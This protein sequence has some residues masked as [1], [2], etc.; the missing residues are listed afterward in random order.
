[1]QATQ[2]LLD[3]I[4]VV[5][6]YAEIYDP[7]AALSN[8]K[9]DISIYP[10]RASDNNLAPEPVHLLQSL[11]CDLCLSETGS[12]FWCAVILFLAEL[13]KCHSQCVATKYHKGVTFR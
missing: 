7:Q 10:K 9:Q 2:A 13:W 8:S 12:M 3:R 5:G 11:P 4:S 1:M 6:K